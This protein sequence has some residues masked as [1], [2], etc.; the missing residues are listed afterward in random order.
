MF[1][2]SGLAALLCLCW[3]VRQWDTEEPRRLAMETD[4]LQSSTWSLAFSPDGRILAAANYDS[5]VRLWETVA[6]KPLPTLRGHTRPISQIVFSR[7]GAYLA[8]AGVDGLVKVWNPRTGELIRT[9]TVDSEA[10]A[11]LSF[12][13]DGKLLATAGKDPCIRL[14]NVGTG[15]LTNMLA[16]HTDVVTELAFSPDGKWIASGGWDGTVRIWSATERKRQIHYGEL[17]VVTSLLFATDGASLIIG[18][19][20]GKMLRLQRRTG[21]FEI[22]AEATAAEP[23]KIALSRDGKTL[24]VGMAE[25]DANRGFRQAR[26]RSPMRIEIRDPG[27]LAVKR[28]FT[29]PRRTSSL[30]GI[31]LSPDGR[32]MAVGDW[33]KYVYVWSLSE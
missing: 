29:M 17:D 14:W 33:G 27:T 11:A 30:T 7:E 25:A 32:T 31:A 3:H 24:A 20:H 2:I 13:Q 18:T 26:G 28:S 15:E 5:T 16:G 10:V 4:A 22:V 12:S 6:W 9:I 8:S 19:R 23:T 21:S 1:K